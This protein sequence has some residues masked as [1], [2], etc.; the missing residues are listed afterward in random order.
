MGKK[1]KKAKKGGRVTP[2][3]TRPAGFVP[4][5]VTADSVCC[6]SCSP[7]PPAAS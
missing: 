5:L 2:K 1:T 4:K 7:A 3:G 6:P